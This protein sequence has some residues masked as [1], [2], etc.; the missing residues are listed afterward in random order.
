MLRITSTTYLNR[1]KEFKDDKSFKQ[2]VDPNQEQQEQESVY[3]KETKRSPS[4]SSTVLTPKNK[5]GASKI[6]PESI[7]FNTKTTTSS[8]DGVDKIIDGGDV[9]PVIEVPDPRYNKEI[10]P[11]IYINPTLQQVNVN[12][13]VVS[14]SEDCTN[15]GVE[16]A[17]ELGVQYFSLGQML[18]LPPALFSYQLVLYVTD[19]GITL[20]DLEKTPGAK[21][22]RKMTNG[23]LLDYSSGSI[24]HS[25]N[26]GQLMK[27][28]MIRAISSK[29]K[30]PNHVLDVTGGFG[31]DAWFIAS[32]GSNVT[33]V[34][35]NPILI[36]LMNIAHRVALNSPN[37]R[38][39]AKRVKIIHQDSVEYLMNIM[40]NPDTIEK[41]DVIYM[42]PMYPMRKNDGKSLSKKDI[43]AV[44]KLVG[45]DRDSSIVF[46]LAKRC[47]KDKV[48]W[49]RP[50]EVPGFPGFNS[51]YSSSDTRY[52]V[53]PKNI[54]PEDKEV[55]NQNEDVEQQKVEKKDN[56]FVKEINK[57]KDLEEE[58]FEDVEESDIKKQEKK[59]KK[60]RK[61][62][63]KLE[64]KEKKEKKENKKKNT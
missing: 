15:R 50:K 46:A 25:V 4:S 58:I 12:Q 30:L 29:K 17:K 56:D 33:I 22:P 2:L 27:S 48:V 6:K 42:D 59:E 34:E 39:V 43:R 54:R 5:S 1:I 8:N 61:E 26:H 18:T 19:A 57:I 32:M 9:A 21:R 51:Y 16:V 13:I 31:R 35:R 62:K 41:P 38:E 63:E 49:K 20:Y 14:S 28:P 24:D 11:G 37:T 7:E 45:G 64:K 40:K 60:E 23:V 44:R 3:L 36:Y 55:E 52:Y 53:Y 10:A 47:I